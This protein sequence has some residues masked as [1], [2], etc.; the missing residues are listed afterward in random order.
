MRVEN[1]PNDAGFL[2]PGRRNPKGRWALID[3][4]PFGS[5]QMANPPRHNDQCRV[6]DR[7][8][9][10]PEPPPGPKY[11]QVPVRGLYRIIKV[12]Q[13]KFSDN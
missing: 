7:K 12:P 13:N 10:R 9:T 8:S 11:R 1:K 3:F 5:L 4:E 2:T 6:T